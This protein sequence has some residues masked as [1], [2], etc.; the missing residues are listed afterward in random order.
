MF[1]ASLVRK[2]ASARDRRLTSP[3][4]CLS[5]LALKCFRIAV[6][7]S[8]AWR[9]TSSGSRCCS[10]ISKWTILLSSVTEKDLLIS[11]SAFIVVNYRSY[12]HVRGVG[13]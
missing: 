1:F 13:L 8:F 5:G 6:W 3:L 12:M 4:K 7:A 11:S 10:S 9:V 2:R